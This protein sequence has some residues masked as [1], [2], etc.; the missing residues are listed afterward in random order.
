MSEWRNI[1]SNGLPDEGRSPES[2][3]RMAAEGIPFPWQWGSGT[4][5]TDLDVIWEMS[6]GITHAVRHHIESAKLAVLGTPYWVWPMPLLL[7]AA[8]LLILQTPIG[9]F[10]EKP[11]QE[12]VAP[13]VLG[14]TAV[15]ALFVYYRV[16]EFFTLLL[17]C[18]AL[19][20]FLRELHFLGTNNGF[21]V[22]VILLAWL[23]SSRRD[24][25]H[26][27]LR[28]RSIGALLSCSLWTYF[29]TKLIDRHYLSFL[30][31][32]VDW[33]DSVEESLETLGHL[34]V[35]ALV[36]VAL[37]VGNIQGRTGVADEPD[38]T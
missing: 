2:G 6:V 35:F 28:R 21:Y 37:R 26:Q 32:Y 18:F 24:A 23:A 1:W 25:I 33:H 12:I 31:E 8:I 15:L 20:L 4:I 30:P 13:V 29:V 11:V 36:V 9:W 34:M 19:A 17:A 38:S 7:C 22:A 16:R 3:Y 14:I 27:F 10:T 5:S